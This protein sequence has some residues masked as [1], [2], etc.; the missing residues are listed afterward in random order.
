MDPFTPHSGNG[1]SGNGRSIN[2]SDALLHCS[3]SRVVLAWSAVT[4][5]MRPTD[6]QA[7]HLRLQQYGAE[8]NLDASE[9]YALRLNGR[10]LHFSRRDL[11]RF[12]NLIAALVQQLP[13]RP[14]H[15][16]DLDVVL[17]PHH[18]IWDNGHSDFS[19]N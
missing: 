14:L 15:W 12:I 7:L 11:R 19:K 6:V 1:R 13:S 17:Q 2:L 16:I 4:L 3:P 5:E 9:S 10:S 18:P 8:L